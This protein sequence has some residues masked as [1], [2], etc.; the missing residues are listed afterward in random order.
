MYSKIYLRLEPLGLELVAAAARRAGHEVRLIDLQVETH[1][2]YFR[3]LDALAAR[4]G[5]LL[6]ATTSPTCPEIVDL[7]KATRDAP[8]RAASSS[9]AATASRSPPTEL[10]AHADGAHRLRAARRGRGR[11]SPHLLEA[12]AHDRGALA[13]VPGVVT[14]DGEGPPPVFVQPP[15]RPAAGARP[16]PPPPQVLHRPARPVRVDRVQPRLPVGLHL[17]QRLDL[18]RPQ[19]PREDARARRRGDRSRSASPACSSSTTSPSSRPSTAWP[20]ARPSRG[21]GIQKRY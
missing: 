5:R 17:L 20:S 21:K 7:A 11:P 3:L 18:L 10:L 19:L 1:A 15:R 4:R 16:A 13:T 14:L 2:D 8:A 9:S 6:G 12:V